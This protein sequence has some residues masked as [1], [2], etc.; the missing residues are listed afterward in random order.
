MERAKNKVIPS[1]PAADVVTM[2]R[3]RVCAF[4]NRDM[5]SLI[6]NMNT[7]NDNNNKNQFP[8]S[9]LLCIPFHR[10]LFD[11]A[12]SLRRNKLSE[13][14]SA[15][16]H[17]SKARR[18]AIDGTAAIRNGDNV[19]VT[20]GKAKPATRTPHGRTGVFRLRH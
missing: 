19:S 8:L 15:L 6:N 11:D 4:Q 16:S 9:N 13:A 1:S 18:R 2:Q 12:T 10:D 17:T 20:N 5:P 7:L 14:V 3:R